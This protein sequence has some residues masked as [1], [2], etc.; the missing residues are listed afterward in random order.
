MMK[1]GI[2][3]LWMKSIKGKGMER[4]QLE[5]EKEPRLRT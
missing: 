4:V 5:R 1:D 3:N 2:E